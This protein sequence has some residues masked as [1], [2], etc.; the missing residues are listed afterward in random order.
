MLILSFIIKR[1]VLSSILNY[2]KIIALTLM[3]F[4]TTKF[5]ITWMVYNDGFFFKFKS[6]YFFIA[7]HIYTGYVI[8]FK[9]LVGLLKFVLT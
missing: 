4:P 2:L 9:N 3:R 1:T 6:Y 7:P 5:L 8:V